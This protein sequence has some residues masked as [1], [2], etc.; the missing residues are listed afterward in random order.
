MNGMVKR[1]VL[2]EIL[3]DSEHLNFY[4]FNV[5]SSQIPSLCVFNKQTQE[6]DEYYW[7]ELWF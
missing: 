2:E 6:N 5:L 3:N 4:L 1:V 7:Q